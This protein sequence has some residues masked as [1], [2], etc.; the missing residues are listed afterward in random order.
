MGDELQSCM[1]I[2]FFEVDSILPLLQVPSNSYV[3][4][5]QIPCTSHFLPILRNGFTTDLQRTCNGPITIGLNIL[6]AEISARYLFCRTT[7]PKC[8]QDGQ[9]QNGHFHFRNVSFAHYI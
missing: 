8:G 9:G 3:I 7:L 6:P 5:L 1:K 2:L 4:P